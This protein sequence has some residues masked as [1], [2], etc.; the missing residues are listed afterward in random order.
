MTPG[1]CPTPIRT[2]LVHVRPTTI[3]QGPR[4]ALRLPSTSFREGYAF[5]TTN[6]I[7]HQRANPPL[8]MSHMEVY[9]VNFVTSEQS[10]PV[11]SDDEWF[12]NNSLSEVNYMAGL[13]STQDTGMTY[14]EYQGTVFNTMNLEN[15]NNAIHFTALPHGSFINNNTHAVHGTHSHIFMGT[16]DYG[17][18]DVYAQPPDLGL[19]F[20][21]ALNPASAI[22]SS[23]MPNTTPLLTPPITTAATP[24]TIAVNDHNC[25]HGHDADYN[26]NT[27]AP[28]LLEQKASAS[29]SRRREKKQGRVYRVSYNNHPSHRYTCHPCRFSTD[30]KRDFARHRETKKHKTKSQQEEE[31]EDM[32]RLEGNIAMG[33]Q[34]R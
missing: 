5:V 9:P 3:N 6:I 27:N 16:P 19:N 14:G 20:N 28:K 4:L 12:P 26:Y 22:R 31:E 34:G 33:R 30:V 23:T 15:N 21:L 17:H 25:G 29:A 24:M 1:P 2:S 7:N 8:D 11:G 10:I 18:V 32:H 13:G